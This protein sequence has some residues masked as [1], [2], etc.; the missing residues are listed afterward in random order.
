MVDG[1]FVDTYI[2]MYVKD[3]STANITTTLERL[4]V[5]MCI[6]V[7]ISAVSKRGKRGKS[8]KYKLV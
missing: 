7:H 4:T 6:L 5:C 8:K 3:I 2:P 1:V